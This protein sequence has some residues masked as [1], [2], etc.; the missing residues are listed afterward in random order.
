MT[1][2]TQTAM[3]FSFTARLSALVETAGMLSVAAIV[4]LCLNAML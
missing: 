2:A 1:T 4:A 3:S